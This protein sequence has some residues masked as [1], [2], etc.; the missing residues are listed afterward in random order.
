M[1]EPSILLLDEA[2][3]SLD[4]DSTQL[5]EEL[6]ESFIGA[7]S[8]QGRLR[9]LIFTTHQSSQVIRLARRVLTLEGG[10][11]VSDQLMG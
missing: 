3:A 8:D 9:T 1:A 11:V 10:L 4:T 6:I 5:L 7:P 2:T